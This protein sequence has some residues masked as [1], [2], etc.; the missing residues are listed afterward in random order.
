MSS[1]IT[2][3]TE[4]NMLPLNENVS[5]GLYSLRKKMREKISP[6]SKKCNCFYL[7]KM[8]TSYSIAFRNYFL[9]QKSFV[10]KAYH[11]RGKCLLIKHQAPKLLELIEIVRPETDPAPHFLSMQFLKTLR[12]ASCPTL[13]R[14]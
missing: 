7:L 5:D 14:N 4:C 3:L 12:I 2:F 10:S 8:L 1:F 6:R 11:T 9:L 13:C